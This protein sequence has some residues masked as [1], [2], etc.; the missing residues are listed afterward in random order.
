M[1]TTNLEDQLQVVLQERTML[2]HPFYQ[3][4]TKGELK[5]EQ[6]QE[7]ARQYFHF[8]AAFPRFLS[9]IHARTDSPSVRQTLLKNLWDEEYGERN[10]RTLWIEFAEALGVSRKEVEAGQ[11]NNQTTQLIEHFEE[12]CSNAPIAEAIATIFAYEG[13][14]PNIAEEKIAGLRDMYNMQP[15]EYEFFSVHMESDIAHSNAEV[16][17]IKAL[18]V[19]EEKTINATEDACERLLGFLDGCYD[20]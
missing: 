5:I 1:T 15:K 10:H 4:W 8:E 20:S 9:A 3:A 7:Y 2:H 6:L 17:A 18:C 11:P 19:D 14:V 13:Q 16:E 12:K